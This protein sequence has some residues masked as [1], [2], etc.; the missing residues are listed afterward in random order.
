MCIEETGQLPLIV[1]KELK[2]SSEQQQQQLVGKLRKWFI[3]TATAFRSGIAS[4]V[5]NDYQQSTN[6]SINKVWGP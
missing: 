4:P 5:D 1:L 3:L 2:L 6:S